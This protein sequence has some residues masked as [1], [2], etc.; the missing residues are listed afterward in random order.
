MTIN[1]KKIH[2][3]R[4]RQYL[5]IE[6]LVMNKRNKNH[7]LLLCTLFLT[8]FGCGKVVKDTSGL[9]ILFEKIEL[10]QSYA[11]LLPE[12]LSNKDI[13]QN[14]YAELTNDYLKARVKANAFIDNLKFKLNVV[15]SSNPLSISK[16]DFR[17]S[18]AY[19]QLQEFIQK[20]EQKLLVRK[21]GNL[22]KV[23][24]TV[25]VAITKEVITVMQENKSKEQ[26]EIILV[27][28]QELEKHKMKKFTD[29]HK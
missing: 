3:S 29:V 23:A 28:Q 21:A 13:T 15:S 26:K 5:F 18:M 27:L 9:E 22:T 19:L 20:S 16:E 12:N 4:A 2:F 17:K 6:R 1:S 8:F 14:E 7:I 10:A 24:I 11:K 25:G